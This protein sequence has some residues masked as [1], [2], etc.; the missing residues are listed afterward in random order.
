MPAA[1][2]E[3]INYVLLPSAGSKTISLRVNRDCTVTVRAPG[4]VSRDDVAEFVAKR[5]GWILEKQRYFKGLSQVYPPKEF[6]N[7]ES[8]DFLGRKLRL[9]LFR[10]A[11]RRSTECEVAERRLKLFLAGQ[12][13]R[14]LKAAASSAIRELYSRHTA[15]RA[16]A[17][18]RKHAASLAIKPGRILIVDPKKR[19]GSCA[20]NGDVRLNWRISMMPPAVIEYVIVHE[21]CHL[22]VHSHSP[23]FWSILKS[24]LPDYENRRAWLRRHGPA[25]LLVSEWGGENRGSED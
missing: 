1:V 11:G 24:I 15:L 4:H 13:G 8:F 16:R 25:V 14:E 21:L 19:W 17:F 18:V 23:K 22:K 7:G 12:T 5:A 3:K 6:K 2:A 10:S 20:R 9:K